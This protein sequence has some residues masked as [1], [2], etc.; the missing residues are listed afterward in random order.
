LTDP[1][2]KYEGLYGATRAGAIQGE[3]S[4]NNRLLSVADT[5]G[6]TRVSA[7]ARQEIDRLN[8]LLPE[9]KKR[10]AADA[11]NSIDRQILG[12]ARSDLD[13]ALAQGAITEED[14]KNLVLAA[15]Q[16]GDAGAASGLIENAVDKAT[17]GKTVAIGEGPQPGALIDYLDKRNALMAKLDE[18]IQQGEDLLT[19]KDKLRDKGIQ[20]GKGGSEYLNEINEVEKQRQASNAEFDETIKQIDALDAER[21]ATKGTTNGPQ[22]PQ[23]QQTETQ[24]Q[25][26]ALAKPVGKRAATD[27]KKA[28][29]G[30]IDAKREQNEFIAGNDQRVDDI[31]TGRLRAL[32]KE[33]GLR[34]K[35]LPSEK[36]RDTQAH[37]M[38]RLPGLFNEFFRLQGVVAKAQEPN[39][40]AKNAQSLQQ[41]TDAIA[42]TDPNAN[43]MLGALRQMPPQQR[44]TLISQMNKQGFDAFDAQAKARVAAVKHE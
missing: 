28:E 42:A 21:A 9:A 4:I 41:I 39:Q 35:D 20:E 30:R 15:R 38:L 3:I 29:Q 16:T 14:A 34:A 5:K 36:Y 13:D 19:E 33:A 7:Q 25:E 17:E 43:Q 24:G 37:K 26:P 32:G 27:I 22:A 1:I 18:L 44:D 6:D 23:T 2:A 10:D 40:K 8:S 31:L 12:S 11:R